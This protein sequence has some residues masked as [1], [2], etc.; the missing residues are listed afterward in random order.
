MFSLFCLRCAFTTV[1]RLLLDQ[2]PYLFGYKTMNFLFQNNPKNLDL[3]NKTDLDVWDCFGIEIN[4]S[5]A[6]LHKTS[7]R[8]CSDFGWMNSHPVTEKKQQNNNKTVFSTFQRCMLPVWKQCWSYLAM[9]PPPECRNV[10][11]Q[12]SIPS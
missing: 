8:I 7:L 4:H 2:L 1:C 5:V 9:F 6:E 10:Y 12:Y 11:F 3:S